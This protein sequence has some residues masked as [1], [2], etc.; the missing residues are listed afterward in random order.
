MALYVLETLTFPMETNDTV[1][2]GTLDIWKVSAP[3][4]LRYKR[5]TTRSKYQE[6]L[7]EA[8]NQLAPVIKTYD[9]DDQEDLIKIMV[10]CRREAAQGFDSCLLMSKYHRFFPVLSSLLKSK[11]IEAAKKFVEHFSNGFVVSS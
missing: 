3:S 4:F 7:T 2:N 6:V 9:K 11:N 10:G 1:N 8:Q 5:P